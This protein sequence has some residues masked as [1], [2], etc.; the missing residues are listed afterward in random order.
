M[1]LPYPKYFLSEFIDFATQHIFIETGSH[2]GEGIAQALAAGFDRVYSADSAL[3]AYQACQQRFMEDW[4][5]HLFHSDSRKFLQSLL[6][7]IKE[8]ATIW[9][10]AHWCASGGGSPVDN[11]LLGELEMIRKYS[12]VRNHTILIDD[13][14]LMG[15]RVEAFPHLLAVIDA[16]T[17][18]N[19]DYK[20]EYR[21][22]DEFPNDI[23][24]ARV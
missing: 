15:N 11:P 7:L 12:D 17:M 22:S 10:D 24:V 9:L 14:R 2:R 13:V 21:D 3:S 5:V 1:S 16:L 19:S 4:R 23:L 8:K 20:I 6:P 18:I